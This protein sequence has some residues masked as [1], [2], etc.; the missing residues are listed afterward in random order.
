MPLIFEKISFNT[1]LLFLIPVLLVIVFPVYFGVWGGTS[2]LEIKEN[3]DTKNAFG[4]LDMFIT[5]LSFLV[6]FSPLFFLLNLIYLIIVS[7][8][9]V[10]LLN[11][12]ILW[13]FLSKRKNGKKL[14]FSIL[15]SAFFPTIG[16]V[17][18]IIPY[19]VVFTDLF[20]A[21]LISKLALFLPP[22]L[23]SFVFC[24]ILFVKR[25]L[26]LLLLIS[27]VL[28]LFGFP[29]LLLKSS[30][31]NSYFL[32]MKYGS[33]PISIV[34]PPDLSKKSPKKSYMATILFNSGAD[35]YVTLDSNQNGTPVLGK[36]YLKQGKFPKEIRFNE[37]MQI[38]YKDLKTIPGF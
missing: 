38:S 22:L 29:Q 26:S 24:L 13:I 32:K 36:L 7:V 21:S 12:S 33:I 9:L 34:I 23:S 28:F 4:I 31:S 15:L 10:F 20:G 27:F 1:F 6:L 25:G 17:F 30:I 8:L 35:L 14:T 18:F 5:I 11:C 19:Y 2:S 37:I 16:G 3:L